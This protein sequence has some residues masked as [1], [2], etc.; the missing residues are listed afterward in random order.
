VASQLAAHHTSR[1]PRFEREEMNVDFRNNVIFNWGFNSVYGGE[2]SAVNMIANFFQPGPATLE[3]VRERILDASGDRGRWFVEQNVVTGAEDLAEDNWQGGVQRPWTHD[4]SAL[5]A[6]TSFPAA[7]V[8]TQSAAAARELVLAQAGAT[9]PRRDAVD[10]R[11]LAEVRTGTATSGRSFSGGG[12]GII[13]SPT[14]VGGWPELKSAP[15]P[16]DSDH[17]GMPD[18]WEKQFGLNAQDGM[19]ER[20][21]PTAMATPT[22][23]NSST[24]P[25]RG[26]K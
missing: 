26:S 23:R 2:R 7:F 25:T 6:R 8:T 13:D 10:E 1:N 12:N 4:E 11:I 22:W 18:D 14:D 24:P 21:T 19:T 9:L 17:D 20:A 3:K 15:A 5:R 16:P